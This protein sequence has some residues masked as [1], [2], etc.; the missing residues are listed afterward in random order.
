LSTRSRQSHLLKTQ[1]ERANYRSTTVAGDPGPTLDTT[2]RP[3]SDSTATPI[4]PPLE[5]EPTA[6]SVSTRREPSW[7][8]TYLKEHGAEIIVVVI[9]FGVLTFFWSQ[10]F[11]LNRELGELK[12]RI[13]QQEKEADRREDR[14][15]SEIDRLTDRL[16]K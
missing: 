3:D 11:S 5:P 6:T 7:L 9:L 2:R 1:E 14:L 16:N 15:Q 13:E 12:V 8:A 10:L 4:P